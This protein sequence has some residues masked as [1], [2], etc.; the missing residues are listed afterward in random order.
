MTGPREKI[1]VKMLCL[2]CGGLAPEG[3]IESTG[4][5]ECNCGSEV[6]FQNKAL[7]RDFA[8]FAEIMAV[9]KSTLRNKA[10]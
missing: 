9:L 10:T 1:A 6:M 3:G 7:S 2:C 8:E 4:N 5:R